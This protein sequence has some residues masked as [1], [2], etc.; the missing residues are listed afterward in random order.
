MDVKVEV[1]LREF[2]QP[3]K[4]TC[5]IEQAGSGCLAQPHPF[6]F[7]DHSLCTTIA[8]LRILENSKRLVLLSEYKYIGNTNI[9]DFDFAFWLRF[10]QT[11]KYI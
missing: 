11:L 9:R 5:L 3:I 1:E 7:T 10:S 6:Q 2:L 8:S 4:L